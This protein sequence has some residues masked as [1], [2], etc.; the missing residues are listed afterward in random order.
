M[1][2][3][4]PRP[5]SIGYDEFCELIRDCTCETLK[6]DVKVIIYYNEEEYE[7]GLRKRVASTI[8]DPSWHHNNM[9]FKY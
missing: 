8:I 7:A 6:G 9:Y 3:E 5:Y 2:F 4:T 1:I